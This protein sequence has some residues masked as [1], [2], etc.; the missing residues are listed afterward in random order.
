MS[1]LQRSRYALSQ[2]FFLSRRSS[3]LGT[4]VV[5]VLAVMLSSCAV[6]VAFAASKTVEFGQY[7]KTNQKNELMGNT[8]EKK[9]KES[10]AVIITATT[11]SFL[12]TLF[13]FFVFFSMFFFCLLWGGELILWIL[14]QLD[15]ICK[16]VFIFIPPCQKSQKAQHLDLEN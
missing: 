8:Q 3:V 6:G 1:T 14:N 7:H 12:I 13:F 5:L 15:S 2:L 10:T 16:F 11:A 4:D 9:K